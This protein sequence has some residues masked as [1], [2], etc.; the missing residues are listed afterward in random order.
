MR[1]RI[2]P[3][4]FN[5]MMMDYEK[6]YKESLE[7]AKKM[8]A[9]ER[10]VVIKALESIFPELQESEDERIIN[11]LISLVQSA[12]EVLLIPTNK[13]ELITW[14]EKQKEQKPYD[15]SY[16]QEKIAKATKTWK[17]VDVDEYLAEVRGEWKPA[18][19]SEEDEEIYK[20]VLQSFE[21]VKFKE[22]HYATGKFT[23]AQV[24]SWLKSLK[25]QSPWKPSDE[26]EV[27]LINTTLSFL[28]DFKKKGYE[29]AMECIDWLKSKLNGNTCE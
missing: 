6:K 1:V 29:N 24:L 26:D 19:W 18:E 14:L 25:P 21:S 22:H 7:K 11:Q 12:G 17:G 20:E 2:P 15:E 13:E 5:D 9:S 27:R 28:D 4:P 16:L 10:G 8:L 23:Y 3:P